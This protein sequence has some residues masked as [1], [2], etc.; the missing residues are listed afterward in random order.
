MIEPKLIREAT[1]DIQGLA[2]PTRKEVFM[3]KAQRYYKLLLGDILYPLMV[4]VICWIP[5]A[6]VCW[7]QN[8]NILWF[9]FAF[10]GGGGLHAYR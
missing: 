6:I 1:L 9:G 2:E 5:T 8:I 3:A 4:A 10:Y 7:Y